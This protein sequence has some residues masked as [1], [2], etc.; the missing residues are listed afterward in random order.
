MHARGSNGALARQLRNTTASARM[1]GV[2]GA[3]T[4]VGGDD[5]IRGSPQS[6]SSTT[7]VDVSLKRPARFLLSRKR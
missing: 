5:R 6:N 4:G 3:Q 7:I 1:D 2:A